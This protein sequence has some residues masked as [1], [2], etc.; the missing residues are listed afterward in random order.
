MKEDNK[1][2]EHRFRTTTGAVVI[3]AVLAICGA[4][5]AQDISRDEKYG[6]VHL[7]WDMGVTTGETADFLANE[8]FRGFG[9]NIGRHLLESELYL[10]LSW[11]WNLFHENVS[12]LISLPDYDV[13]GDQWRRVWFSPVL[14]EIG[15]AW[16]FQTGPLA[17]HPFARLGIGGYRFRKKVEIGITRYDE[18]QW[19][20]VVSPA[21]GIQVPLYRR[22]RGVMDMRYHYL[23]E[24]G[25]ETEQSYFSIGFGLGYVL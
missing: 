24:A 4:A 20:I 6:V 19:H 17:L 23:F 16:V 2:M 15:Y 12:E 18:E 11:H 9:V 5:R 3:A 1:H 22:I 25:D 21:L 10:G 7:T 14:A 13:S 8:S